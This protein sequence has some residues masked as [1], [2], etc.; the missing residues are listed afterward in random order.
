MA[1]VLK[2][3]SWILIATWFVV[4]MG[5]VSSEAD[6]VLCNQ[7]EVILCDTVQNGFVTSGD[8]RSLLE[9]TGLHLQGYS[10]TE[11]NTRTLEQKLEV[12]PYIGNAE[13]SKDITGKLEVKVEQRR[14]LIRIMPQGKR[15]FYLDTEGV[16]LPLSERFTPLILLATGYIPEAPSTGKSGKVLKELLMFSTFLTDHEFWRDQVVQIYVNRK[17]EYELI[18]RVGAHHIILGSM[19]QWQKKLSNLELLYRQ[20]LSRFGWN[21][22]GTINLKYTNQVICTKR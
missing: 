22:Y 20:G 15:G 5:F 13:V 14:P 2:I 17:G 12:N 19:D 18:P 7:I 11:I 10:M 4:I 6:Q 8:I 3:L 1:R 16:I 9:A 21:T